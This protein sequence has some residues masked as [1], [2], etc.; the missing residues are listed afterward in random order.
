MSLIVFLK[1]KRLYVRNRKRIEDY[2]KNVPDELKKKERKRVI[3]DCLYARQH[4]AFSTLEYF[5]HDFP[6][7]T[8]EQWLEY[9]SNHASFTIFQRMNKNNP[10]H[11]ADKYLVYCDFKQ[12][13]GRE[14]CNVVQ[15]SDKDSFFAFV[16]E[17]GAVLLK[18]LRGSLG[19]DVIKFR[20]SDIHGKRAF[21]KLL[22][23][24]PDGFIAEELIKQSEEMAKFNPTSVNTLRITTVRMDDRVYAEAFLRVGRM[25][26]V[27]DNVAKGGMVCSL[28]QQTGEITNVTDEAG[29]VYLVHPDSGYKLA[30]NY[31]PRLNDALNMARTMANHIPNFRYIGWDLALT[32]NG[33]VL[34]ELNAKANTY[35]IQLTMGRG[36]RKDFESFLKEIGESSDFPEEADE[37]FMNDLKKEI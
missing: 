19:D 9:L 11:T 21:E 27:V 13:F 23:K 36:I 29:N 24:Y 35:C 16:K 33:W 14:A 2:L 7:K 30:G 28:N 5:M 6:H 32:D 15:V 37:I 10:Y 17:K 31:V 22:K 18:P 26:S 8:H 20:E 34:V 3:S 1:E 12:F 4:T 25:F